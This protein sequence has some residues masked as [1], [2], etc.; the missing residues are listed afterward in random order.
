MK[1][2]VHAFLMEQRL[3][4]IVTA[5]ALLLAI[6]VG[7]VPVLKSESDPEVVQ[8]IDNGAELT[9]LNKRLTALEAVVKDGSGTISPELRAELDL[10]ARGLL[11]QTGRVSRLKKRIEMPA[12]DGDAISRVLRAEL[13]L[14]AKGLLNQ[15]GRVSRLKKQVAAQGDDGDTISP[16]LRAELDLIAKGLLNQTGRVSALKKQV[17]SLSSLPGKLDRIDLEVINLSKAVGQLHQRIRNT[18]PQSPPVADEIVELRAYLTKMQT[19]V[20]GVRTSLAGM[21]EQLDAT[22]ATSAGQD[23]SLTAIEAKLDQI[24]Q[25]MTD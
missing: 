10:I 2:S 1:E 13:D 6:S 7:L 14:M 21:T 4:L 23:G 18:N 11:N 12:A 25:S 15:T 22:T 17:A 9:A 20:D 16:L 24:L 8:T 19:Q 5:L 3:P